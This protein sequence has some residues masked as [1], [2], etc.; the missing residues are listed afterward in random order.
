MADVS[1][2]AVLDKKIVE[3]IDYIKT[4]SKKKVTLQKLHKH[5]SKD[6]ITI[7]ENFLKS[8][9][10]ELEEVGVVENQGTENECFFRLVKQVERN[11][12]F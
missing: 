9:L 6:G 11:N 4:V 2:K 7:D 3:A 5:L 12:I 8:L 1:D 10:D